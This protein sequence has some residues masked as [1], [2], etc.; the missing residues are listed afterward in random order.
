MLNMSNPK[1]APS[2]LF[3][4]ELTHS[5][6]DEIME[7]C[8]IAQ[9]TSV[10]HNDGEPVEIKYWSPY[11]IQ[12][13]AKLFIDGDR[14]SDRVFQQQI[15]K[16]WIAKNPIFEIE[17]SDDPCA[18]LLFMMWL[19]LSQLETS[20]DPDEIADEFKALCLY[21][22]VAALQILISTRL[23][24]QEDYIRANCFS[25][26]RKERDEP[27][28]SYARERLVEKKS[29]MLMNAI[30][31]MNYDCIRN[32]CNDEDILKILNANNQQVLIK[33]LSIEDAKMQKLFYTHPDVSPILVL[34]FGAVLAKKLNVEAALA[35]MSDCM[36]LDG[37]E[38]SM[39]DF[40]IGESSQTFIRSTTR[41]ESFSSP[42]QND[43]MQEDEK[44]KAEMR[45]D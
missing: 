3:S 15:L 39:S 7:A 26:K 17:F 1:I 31:K 13:L 6:L 29:K 11:F 21:P 16:E 23:L 19:K 8:F 43:M 27:Q 38:D 44:G 10:L 9:N 12:K 5:E 36:D 14:L 24:E 25:R 4:K 20:V 2:H 41:Q 35:P 34:L 37:L 32:I 40:H 33:M 18:M 42:D 28:A 30:D 45:F 22:I